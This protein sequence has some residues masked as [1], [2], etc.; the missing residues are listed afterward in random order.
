MHAL[1]Q[2]ASTSEY[3]C[4]SHGDQWVY[5]SLVYSFGSNT[6]AMELCDSVWE[7]SILVSEL[8]LVSGALTHYAKTN[9][10][11]L[12]CVSAWVRSYTHFLFAV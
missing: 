3:Y 10:R 7:L 4:A 5:L 1:S 6:L 8:V 2:C 12:G 9:R 11:L